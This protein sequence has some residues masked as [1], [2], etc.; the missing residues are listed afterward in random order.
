MTTISI[1]IPAALEEF[2]NKMIKRGDAPTKA[3]VVRQALVRFAE[4]EAI[5]SVL[6]S[7]QEIKDGK[8]L[9]GDIRK[10]IKRLP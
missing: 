6:R 3:E 5:E 8:I 7:E 4:D 9:R 1:P 2:I 10:I